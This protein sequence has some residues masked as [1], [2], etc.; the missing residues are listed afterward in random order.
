M[1][2]Y[3]FIATESRSGT[4]NALHANDNQHFDTTPSIYVLRTLIERLLWRVS[5]LK[6]SQLK[7]PGQEVVPT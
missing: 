4:I 1:P 5:I 2:S 3:T 6:N 7:F